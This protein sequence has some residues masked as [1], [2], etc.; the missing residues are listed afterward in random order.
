[1]QNNMVIGM[2]SSSP[3]RSLR[4]IFGE[5]QVCNICGDDEP[6]YHVDERIHTIM[7]RWEWHAQQLVLSENRIEYLEKFLEV[8]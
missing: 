2:T 5:D 7:Q 8:K 4:L 6:D 1:M 3:T